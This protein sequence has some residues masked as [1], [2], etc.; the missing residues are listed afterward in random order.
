MDAGRLLREFGI[1]PD[2]PPPRLE[3]P[4]SPL[5]SLEPASP[6][7]PSSE[8]PKN[9]FRLM[10]IRLTGNEALGVDELR[11]VFASRLGAEIDLEGINGIAA[12]LAARYREA[13]YPLVRA[14]VEPQKVMDGV[15]TI[16][17]LET[18]YENIFIENSSRLRQMRAAAVLD[19]R[20]RPDGGV[21]GLRKNRRVELAALKKRLRLLSE[22]PG[23]KVKSA[24]QA[25]KDEG[26]PP[27]RTDLLVGLENGR[28]FL[29]SA[30]TNNHG[31]EETGRHRS[32]GKFWLNNS[33]RLGDQFFLHFLASDRGFTWARAS[34]EV[35]IGSE[36]ARAGIGASRMDYSLSGPVYRALGASGLSETVGLWLSQPLIIEDGRRLALR[37]HYDYR[38]MED[39][40]RAID[41]TDYKHAN[42]FGIALSGWKE[43]NFGW[44]SAKG[45]TT[46]WNLAATGGSLYLPPGDRRLL[47]DAGP[48][49]RGAFF[50]FG[51]SISRDQR[52]WGGG[53]P[54][55]RGGSLRLAAAG[56]WSPG[57]LDSSEKI[58]LGGPWA[59]RGY[60]NGEVSGDSG[61]AFTAE[62]R[63][64]LPR[65]LQALAGVDVGFVKL[66]AHNWLPPGMGPNYRTLSA[67][68]LGLNWNRPGRV[69]VEATAA[70]RLT[71]AAEGGRDLKPRIWFSGSFHF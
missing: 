19:G 69:G 5:P 22:I 48:K 42:L 29:A 56:L 14:V 27:D 35:G 41:L 39:R 21:D 64:A 20:D 45:G 59:V 13:G 7:T 66:A 50:H 2:L 43:D 33:T 54:Q 46:G 51:G 36:G 16:R 18:R 10:D 62:Y 30:E 70:W 12:G 52:L 32:G 11:E 71:R 8:A 25:P 23:I 65:G 47:D 37:F 68:V 24:F 31:N 40:Y 57:G 4:V 6:E 53:G 3:P 38:R 15:V 63:Q 9:V 58:S 60:P 28:R 44:A 1:I 26:L 61:A 34:W 55:A 49:T 67:A 17:I